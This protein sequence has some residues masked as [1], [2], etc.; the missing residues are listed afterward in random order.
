M[1]LQT[2]S[3]FFIPWGCGCCS[4]ML[5]IKVS[6]ETVSST[7]LTFQSCCSGN[8]SVRPP[9][10]E[11]LDPVGAF[12][13]ILI[14]I[15]FNCSMKSSTVLDPH[16]NPMFCTAFVAGPLLRKGSRFPTLKRPEKRADP[17]G[18]FCARC[19]ADPMQISAMYCW[20]FLP[21]GD[22]TLDECCFGGLKHC[23]K[24]SGLSHIILHA[25]VCHILQVLSEHCDW[26]WLNIW[27][28][29]I[30]KDTVCREGTLQTYPMYRYK[31]EEVWGYSSISHRHIE[32]YR[33]LDITFLNSFEPLN[34]WCF[35]FYE[36]HRGQWNSLLTCDDLCFPHQTSPAV[37][38]EVA[39]VEASIAW[40]RGE[41]LMSEDWHVRCLLQV[42]GVSW[43]CN[44]I[45]WLANKCWV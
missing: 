19:M 12:T 40:Y 29:K 44:S 41:P 13:N 20:F 28:I 45:I 26:T 18:V 22:S 30:E 21:V 25:G 4:T 3:S 2:Q 34:R 5:L 7:A 33:D 9:N 17:S 37:R 15:I 8:E 39:F 24:P 14:S 10:P 31:C 23:L 42:A 43:W 27:H 36:S 6:I 38:F 11:I 1:V 32:I 16:S 35:F